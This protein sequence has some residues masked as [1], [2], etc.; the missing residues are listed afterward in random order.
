MYKDEERGEG[1]GGEWQRDWAEVQGGMHHLHV[2]CSRV[3]PRI[4]HQR[5]RP[6]V[7]KSSPR[8]I[9]RPCNPEWFRGVPALESMSNHCVDWQ[10]TTA[11][12][13]GCV[14]LSVTDFI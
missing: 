1:R 2:L 14:Y 12:W 10:A 13:I 7:Q 4:G 5:S 8:Y 6:L 9:S 11:V 3:V